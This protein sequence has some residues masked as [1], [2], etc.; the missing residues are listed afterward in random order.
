MKAV[1]RFEYDLL[2]ILHAILRRA[3]VDAATNLVRQKHPRP[4]CLSADAVALVQ[5]ALAKG[6]VLLLAR[7]GGWQPERFLRGEKPA[8]GRLWQRTSPEELGLAFSGGTL[9]FLLWLTAAGWDEKQHFFSDTCNAKVETIADEL[10]L[11]LA[12]GVLH[13]QE[14]GP[15]LR[16]LGLFRKLPLLW[17]FYPDDLAHEKIPARLPWENWTTGL[18]ACILEAWQNKLATRWLEMERQKGVLTDGP[19][20]Q[21]LGSAQDAVLT[22]F[23]AAVEKAGR[24]NLARFLLRLYTQLLTPE[25]TAQAWVGSMQLE[26]Q[27]LA[28][29]M[30]I[31]RTALTVLRQIDTLQRWERQARTVGYFDEGYHA[32]KFWQAEWEHFQGDMLT[33]R[34]QAIR[35]ELEPLQGEHRETPLAPVFRGEGGRQ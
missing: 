23:L 4:K 18:G 35:R 22:G 34:A 19:M 8:Q 12:F 13:R 29:R 1:S 6:C 27:R 2:R 30:E 7:E 32:A 16:S 33:E 28:D 24:W 10:F 20:M 17:L 3:P 9:E 5:D 14:F 31:Y 11:V 26:G 21:Q 15:Y 25:V